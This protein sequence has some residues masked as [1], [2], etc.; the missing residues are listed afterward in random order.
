[1]LAS[2]KLNKTYLTFFF[3]LSFL[4][5]WSAL[6]FFVGPRAIVEYI[7][8]ENGYLVAFLVAAFGGLSSV[9]SA[10]FYATLVTLAAGGLDPV[11]LGVIAGTGV[12]IGDCLFFYLGHTGGDLLTGRMKRFFER[13]SAWL[14]KG[15]G[16]V[17]PVIVFIYAGF[18]PLPNDILTISLA[19]AKIRWQRIILPLWAGNIIL[20]ILIAEAVRHGAERWQELL[21]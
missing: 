12:T 1:M 4:L 3:V 9:S 16:W 2:V 10:S 17:V 19:M 15:P 8:V 11:M 13:L 21:I 6:L 7:G 5:A 20:V 18:T 14:Q